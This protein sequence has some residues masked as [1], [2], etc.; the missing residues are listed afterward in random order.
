MSQLGQINGGLLGA[1]SVP[2]TSVSGAEAPI[3][4]ES[5]DGSF[6]NLLAKTEEEL[7][8]LQSLDTFAEFDGLQLLKPS[9]DP[10]LNPALDSSAKFAIIA[11][12]TPMTAMP[13]E[14]E[15]LMG[16]QLET[17]EAGSL[18]PQAGQLLPVASEGS[19]LP[20]E[21]QSALQTMV[22]AVTET[23]VEAQGQE[24]AAPLT[25]A[26]AE[27]APVLSV[28]TT[29]ILPTIGMQDVPKSAVG[30]TVENAVLLQEQNLKQQQ[31]IKSAPVLVNNKVDSDYLSVD[32]GQPRAGQHSNNQGFGMLSQSQQAQNQLTLNQPAQ[33]QTLAGN[34]LG[35]ETPAQAFAKVIES[36]VGS[37]ELPLA[38]SESGVDKG[39]AILAKLQAIPVSYRS[40]AGTSLASTFIQT[41]VA[42]PQWGD[43]VAERMVWF[44]VK[45]VASAELKLDPPELGP[46]QVRITTQG[47]QTNITFTSQ[48]LAVRDA[49]DQSLPRL[50]EIFSEN[51][52][53]LS[54]VDVSEQGGE[55]QDT[56]KYD[57]EGNE[58]AGSD[59]SQD[60]QHGSAEEDLSQ[61]EK[62]VAGIRLGLVDDYA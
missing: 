27:V 29:E 57:A 32:S 10:S 3:S 20:K 15:P 7:L 22:E 18:L 25:T 53:N 48:H 33:N 23:A 50:R 38:G 58:L 40:S 19:K 9:S 47:D 36:T 17:D 41:P 11:E 60:D 13:L 55:R 35:T 42:T 1:L 14:A 59:S 51:G 61:G 37:S 52:L 30:S 34:L 4:L 44:S 31:S 28:A 21:L 46:L 5:L 49:L 26:Q 39:A 62:E 16:L 8:S 12:N 45:S 56:R 54:N 24:L 43:A 2:S 6:S